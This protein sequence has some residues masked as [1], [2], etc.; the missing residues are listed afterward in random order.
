[1]KSN[2]A[3]A[4]IWLNMVSPVDDAVACVTPKPVIENKV[5]FELPPT[6]AT[7]TLSVIT[8]RLPSVKLPWMLCAPG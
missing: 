2:G 1:M 8:P 3:V 4:S 6:S 5:A 7:G